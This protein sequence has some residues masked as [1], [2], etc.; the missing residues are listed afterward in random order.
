MTKVLIADD[1]PNIRLSLAMILAD[2]G[3]EVM[4]AGDGRGTLELARHERPDVILLDVWMPGMHGFEVLKTLRSN[5][6]TESIP[7]V[8]LTVLEAARGERAGMSLGV[9][10]YITKPW[11][12]GM[13]E[14]AIKVALREAGATAHET[15]SD[16][17]STVTKTGIIQMDQKLRG[18]LPPSSLTLV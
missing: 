1:Q 3:Y 11:E 8:M 18:G 10:H 2:A 13:V 15:A 9:T 16:E 12:P 7:V 4:E 17:V 5:P 6:A 14:A